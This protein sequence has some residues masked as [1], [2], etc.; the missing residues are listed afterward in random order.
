MKKV[1]VVAGE[2]SRREHYCRSLES[3][4][5]CT[6]RASGVAEGQWCFE[7]HMVEIVLIDSRLSHGNCIELATIIRDSDETVPIVFVMEDLA[8]IS[9]AQLAR[10]E[11]RVIPRFDSPGPLKATMDAIVRELETEEMARAHG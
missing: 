8:A 7:R 10:F 4:G 9:A 5:F 1:L 11:A 6:V 3:L 2:Q